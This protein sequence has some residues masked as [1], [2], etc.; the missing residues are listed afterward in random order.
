MVK[1]KRTAIRRDS[2]VKEKHLTAK[3]VEKGIRNEENRS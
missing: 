1:M 3:K 2:D